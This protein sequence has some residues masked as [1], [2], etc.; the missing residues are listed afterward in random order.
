MSIFRWVLFSLLFVSCAR[1]SPEIRSKAMRFDS[2]TPDIAP[3]KDDEFLQ[4][5]FKEAI[6][7]LEKRPLRTM[8]FGDCEISSGEYAKVLKDSLKAQGGVEQA[9]KD[10]FS[11]Y[12]VYGMDKWGEVLLTSYY[13]PLIEGRKNSEG[14]FT[15]PLFSIPTD[16]VEV[17]MKKFSQQDLIEAQVIRS[18]V[19]ARII[20]SW[21]G[22]KKVIP[23]YSREE[24]DKDFS[25]LSKT[26][27]VLAYVKPIEAFFFHI[28]GSGLVRFK[29]G[30]TV[31][32]GYAAQNGHRYYSI[33]KLLYDR[34]AKEDMTKAKIES[35]LAQLSDEE[36][37][38]FLANN[39]SYVFFQK[40]DKGLGRTTF[41]PEVIDRGT[42]A[43]DA[44]LISLGSLALLSF[45][46]PLFKSEEE[47]V[48][49]SFIEESRLVWAHDTGGAI[50]G[51]GRADLYWGKGRPAGQAAGVINQRAKLWILGPKVCRKSTSN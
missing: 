37:F 39:P 19:S 22:V 43:V 33:G 13:S 20:D 10:D 21:N 48:P 42:I 36:L 23:F 45:E 3:I 47:S 18:K 30:E 35:Y 6:A 9:L 51:A 12:E 40:L 27:K 14:L 15:Y 29:N 28:Q 31:S 8:V 7:S 26:A 50:K 2:Q 24:I 46:S 16:L 32:L 5:G 1:I 4:N 25:L 34:I 17:E 41:G 11:W 44:S 38:A 49:E